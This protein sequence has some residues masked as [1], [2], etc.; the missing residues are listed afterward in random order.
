MVQMGVEHHKIL[1]GG[2]LRQDHIAADPVVGGIPVLAHDIRCLG[3]P[4]GAFVHQ[5]IEILVIEDRTA[6]GDDGIV[7][8]GDN[9]VILRQAGHQ[10]VVLPDGGLLK[11]DDPRCLGAD[12]LHQ[13]VCPVEPASGAQIQRGQAAD[14]A[15]HHGNGALLR[16]D[17]N[18]F[19]IYQIVGEVPAKHHRGSQQQNQQA[20][21]DGFQN[22]FHGDHLKK[23]IRL[24]ADNCNSFDTERAV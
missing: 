12:I 22:L 16:C 23:S 8:V 7:P 15:A 6:L 19:G 3:Q 21:K 11:T 17:G 2:F 14:I 5:V 10:I 20:G 9:T 13:Q 4:E 1:S 18:G 24:S